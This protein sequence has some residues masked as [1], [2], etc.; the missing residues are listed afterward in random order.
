M[1]RTL[2]QIRDEAAQLS[3]EERGALADS[4]WESLLSPEEREVQQAW[5]EEAERRIE[6]VRAGKAMT[7]PWEE[8]RRELLE[9]YTRTRRRPSRRS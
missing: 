8:V 9:K 3:E 2:D 7:I 6:E 5:I 4:L 1:P